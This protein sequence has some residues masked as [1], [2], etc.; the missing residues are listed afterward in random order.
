MVN[1]FE[2]ILRI[3]ARDDAIVERAEKRTGIGK[4][5]I[6]YFLTRECSYK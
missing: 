3:E 5:L 6:I 4:Y 1:I 2:A